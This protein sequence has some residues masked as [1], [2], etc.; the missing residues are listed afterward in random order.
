VTAERGRRDDALEASLASF[1]GGPGVFGRYVLL[2]E[3]G[4]G[5]MG[6]VYRARD[7]ESGA[8]VALKVLL[9][10]HGLDARDVA[11]FA[12]EARVLA[13]VSHEGIVGVK[14]AGAVGGV[15]FLALAFVR[16]E[17]L[18]KL[19]LGLA[20]HVTLLAKIARAVGAAHRASIVH[21]DLKPSN[22]L[23][24][25]G[26][27]EPRV[28]DFGLAFDAR[29]TAARLSQTGEVLG[30][31][32]Y[33]APETLL[34][35]ARPDDPRLD[36][37]ALGVMLHERLAGRHPFHERGCPTSEVVV[38]VVRGAPSLVGKRGVDPVL[39]ALAA[40]A[41]A[42]D[43]AGRPPDGDA[44][45][46][47]LEEWLRGPKTPVA[48]RRRLAWLVVPIALG[49]VVVG[50]IIARSWATS[51]RAPA[52]PALPAAAPPVAPAP[53]VP[54][55]APPP[56]APRPAPPAE[57]PDGEWLP[58]DR[59]ARAPAATEAT[60]RE[61]LERARAL[62]TRFPGD[63]RILGAI[64]WTAIVTPGE[65]H[66][67]RRA[68][69]GLVAASALRL[70]EEVDRGGRLCHML[71][72]ERAAAD[73]A[74]LTFAD[75]GAPPPRHG[76]FIC[77]LY[78]AGQE[79]VFW[80]DRAGELSDRLLRAKAGADAFGYPTLAMLHAQKAMAFVGV[81]DAE[82]AAGEY[83][84]A[85][86]TATEE[87]RPDFVGLV[88]LARAGRLTATDLWRH[89]RIS[90]GSTPFFREVSRLDELASPRHDEEAARGFE[91]LAEQSAR[92]GRAEQAAC[93][94]L[95][96]ARY[97]GTGGADDAGRAALERALGLDL[98]AAPDTRALVCRVAARALLERTKDAAR[99]EA[100]ARE[101]VAP[102][103]G[104]DRRSPGEIAD[105]WALV[106][107]A[108]LAA[109]DLP[110]AR[111][112]IESGLSVSPRDRRELDSLAASAR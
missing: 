11:R 14:D 53:T 49:L 94:L 104:A 78:L 23:V 3:V 13:R 72:F 47:E 76:A 44:F 2:E 16:G 82:A 73:V 97:H 74:E 80:P 102:V 33:M 24:E 48:P 36:V 22:V 100:L 9:P 54:R 77:Q 28:V 103:D 56:A 38:R 65:E 46:L 96:A 110:G 90:L 107:R 15:P 19:T 87:E 95:R 91:D 88:T 17:P 84:A 41:L 83:E 50:A 7:R 66:A 101:A 32:A 63:P 37:Y 6:V 81:G 85:A 58:I 39:A 109:N 93:A 34:G 35:T 21:R 40:R 45:A 43:P 105:G 68:V 52:V 10:G 69:L 26:T 4:R 112:A 61:V 31:P 106:A 25:L 12:L 67:A 111:K 79:P 5:G 51:A 108:R 99:A 55:L 29:R 71:G 57:A 75:G 62:A 98:G 59:L 18:S 60:H 1:K 8:E 27:G 64:A 70:P 30:T 42:A 92:A 20:E 89:F 86:A